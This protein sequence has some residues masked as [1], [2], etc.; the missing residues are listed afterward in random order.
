MVK[1]SAVQHLKLQRQTPP[2]PSITG[3]SERRE[4]RRIFGIEHS[5][6]LAEFMWQI[7]DVGASLPTVT[8]KGAPY[9]D[10]HKTPLMRPVLASSENLS[11]VIDAGN[12]EC[13]LC[14]K[15]VEKKLM[16]TH[17]RVHLRVDSARSRPALRIVPRGAR[18]GD[19]S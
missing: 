12:A 10:Q 13:T 9:T 3:V 15:Q 17:S 4:E 8:E 7:V 1:A 5:T 2:P 18:V 16:R 19:I 6:L 11:T 14:Q